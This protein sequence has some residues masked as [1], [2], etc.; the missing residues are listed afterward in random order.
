MKDLYKKQFGEYLEK[1]MDELKK[2][3][4]RRKRVN[5]KQI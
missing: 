2:I 4:N 1:F 5:R 3:R